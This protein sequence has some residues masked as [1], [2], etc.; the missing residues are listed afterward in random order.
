MKLLNLD[1]L[2]K[3]LSTYQHIINIQE[4]DNVYCMV[5]VNLLSGFDNRLKEL[6]LYVLTSQNNYSK[7][8]MSMFTEFKYD[9]YSKISIEIVDLFGIPNKG[10][11]SFIM[12]TFLKYIQ[13]YQ[14]KYVY[15]KLSEVDEKDKENKNRRNHFYKKF[16]FKIENSYI[17]LDMNK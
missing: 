13:H 11:G 16:G 12:T 17:H 7:P 2:S 1:I 14:P 5:T 4:K 8:V 6:D 3:T 10:Y 9:I 15:G